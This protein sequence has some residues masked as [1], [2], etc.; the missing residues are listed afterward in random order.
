MI[1]PA[2]ST[3]VGSWDSRVSSGAPPLAVGMLASPRPGELS[4]GLLGAG[5]RPL[6]AAES[7][8][9]VSHPHCDGAHRHLQAGTPASPPA[10]PQVAVARPSACR[11]P[12]ATFP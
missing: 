6:G 7:T 4:D 2:G 3:L 10:S 9:P 5:S 1:V 11:D 12:S 8:R